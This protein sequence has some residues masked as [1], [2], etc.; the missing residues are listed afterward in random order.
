MG[1]LRLL[2]ASAVVLYHSYHIFG[3]RMTGGMASVQAFYMISG[4]YMALILNEKYTS[5]GSWKLFLSNRFLRIYPLYWAVLLIVLLVSV[6]GYFTAGNSFFLYSWIG[7]FSQ[8]RWSTILLFIV[9][10]LFLFGGDW[11]FFSIIGKN[12]GML[13]YA[14]SAF[15]GS[16]QTFT[17]L[18]VPQAWSVGAELSFYLLAPLLVRRSW[19]IQVIIVGASLFLRYYLV[20]EKFR[21]WDPW[22]YRYFPNEIAL[23]LLGSLCWQI[24]HRLKNITIPAWIGPAAWAIILV[25]V[26]GFDFAAFVGED[27]RPFVFYGLLFLCLPFIFRWSKDFAADRWLGE[28]SYPL[29]IG[30]LLIVML[31]RKWFFGTELL[32]WYG[33]ISL[34]CSFIFAWLLMYFI[35]RPIEKIRARRAGLLQV[36]I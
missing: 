14:S 28:L 11:L 5:P 13:H 24:Y 27:I 4:F 8:L 32:P 22:S 6:I 29:Y 15:V 36:R 9:I 30:H 20:T 31:F 33:V 1:S 23:F 3:V 7:Y 10:N 17:F 19:W 18:L 12:D 16:P 21:S 26:I 2:L 35:A 25:S 34:V